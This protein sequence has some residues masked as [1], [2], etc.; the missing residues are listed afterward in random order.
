MPERLGCEVLQKARY[1]NT[2]TFTFTF[3]LCGQSSNLISLLDVINSISY[4]D[5][6]E[7]VMHFNSRRTS[8]PLASGGG[9]G[10][11]DRPEHI[12]AIACIRAKGGHFKYLC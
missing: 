8:G 5:N 1:I 12:R 10:S 2:L 11:S 9:E 4:S 3:L 7:D 6:T